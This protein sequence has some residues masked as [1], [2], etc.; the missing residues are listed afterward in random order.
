LLSQ[1]III[2][3]K[4]VR[5]LG[6]LALLLVFEFI[7]LVIHPWL[8]RITHHSPA[9]MLLILVG[10]ASLLIPLHHR[11]EKWIDH[12]MVSKNKRLR[13]SIARRIV[14]RLEKEG[15]VSTEA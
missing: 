15:N 7:N 6:V 14:A 8:E 11:I 10:I 9:L 13:L 5:F 2:N 1:S 12:K 3:E 4:W